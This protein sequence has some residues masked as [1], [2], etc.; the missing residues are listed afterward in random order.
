MSKKSREEKH[1]DE[2]AVMLESQIYNVVF[3]G[4]EAVARGTLHVSSTKE[5]LGKL[6]TNASEEDRK[7]I[8]IK[9]LE[10]LD[11]A[12]LSLESIHQEFSVMSAKYR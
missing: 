12:R 11:K 10:N 9:V 6:W 3:S 4:L 5:V 2:T 7:E 1:V 8:G